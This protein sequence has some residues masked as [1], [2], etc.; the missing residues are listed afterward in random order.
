MTHTA[1]A[2]TFFYIIQG[3]AKA[4]QKHVRLIANG[5]K[6]FFLLFFNFSFR[7]AA[8]NA[9]PLW[10]LRKERLPGI[11]QGKIVFVAALF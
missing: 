3:L 8:M 6:N 4:R 2:V 11:G 10:N 9:P 7:K 1:P 5:V